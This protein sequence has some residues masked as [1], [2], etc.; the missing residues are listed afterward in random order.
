MDI[1]ERDRPTLIRMVDRGWSNG[2]LADYMTAE[3]IESA[4]RV[5]A[6]LGLSTA[7]HRGSRHKGPRPGRWPLPEPS[8]GEL[9]G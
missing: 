8:A 9:P 7:D 1:E 5:L 6:A 2:D 3:Q 4:L